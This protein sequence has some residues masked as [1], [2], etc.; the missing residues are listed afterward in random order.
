MKRISNL[1]IALP[2]IALLA[3]ALLLVTPVAAQENSVAN[4]ISVGGVGEA[5]GTP[6]MAIIELGVDMSAEDVGT[7]FTQVNDV[8]AAITAALSDLGIDEK[9]IQTS[10]FNIYTQDNYSPDGQ[11]TGRSYRAQNTVRITVHDVAQTADVINA[12]V[13]AGANNVYN[14]TFGVADTAELEAQ[15]RVDAVANA[16]ERAE[17]LATALGLAVGAPISIAENIGG[18]IGPQPLF[19]AANFAVAEAG[20]AQ[21]NQG[22]FAVTVQVAVV[23]ALV[24]PGA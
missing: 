22:Q 17:Q 18:S 9:D 24:N 7:A 11:I 4:T 1:K 2:V 20:G 23:F 21:I 13:G 10:S 3:L 14:L 19:A 5:S 6:D 12:A 15:A 16:R 8:M